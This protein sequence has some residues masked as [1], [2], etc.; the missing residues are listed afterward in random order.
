MVRTLEQITDVV[1]KTKLGEP[2]VMSYWWSDFFSLT[3]TQESLKNMVNRKRKEVITKNAP[4]EAKSFLLLNEY[5]H[6]RIRYKSVV[7]V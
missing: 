3:L 6:I 1:E 4:A 7:E 5:P 2:K